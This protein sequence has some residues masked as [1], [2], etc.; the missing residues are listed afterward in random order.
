MERL[1]LDVLKKYGL[2][3]FTAPEMPSWRSPARCLYHNI[4]D[5]I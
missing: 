2:C 1:S 5:S 4:K 3:V